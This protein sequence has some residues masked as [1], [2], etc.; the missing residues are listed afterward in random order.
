MQDKFGTG[1]FVRARGPNGRFFACD[2]LYLEDESFRVFTVK[3]LTNNRDVDQ[4]FVYKSRV[5]EDEA[6]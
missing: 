5:N 4:G 3:F 1:V 2:V 6:R